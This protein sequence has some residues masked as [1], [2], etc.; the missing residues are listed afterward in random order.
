MTI[1]F[2]ALIGYAW[3]GLPS[4]WMVARWSGNLS[5]LAEVRRDIGEADAH[6]LLK[7]SGGRAATIAAAMDVLKAFGPVLAASRLTDPYAVAACA[8]ATVAG[9]CWPPVLTRYA[10]RG[11]AAAAGAFLGFLPVEMTAAGIVRVIGSVAKGGG[12]ASTIGFVAIPFIGW[13]RRQPAP[14]V[15]AAFAMN[16]LIF[17]RRVEGVGRDVELGV[18]RGRAIL[19][20]V[21]LDASAHREGQTAA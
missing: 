10:G 11:L 16:V 20:R 19:R 3:G 8:V 17:V 18:P 9:H 2:W 12:L 21:V 4:T 6:L 5:V 1:F 14:Y 13:Y 7:R 15:V